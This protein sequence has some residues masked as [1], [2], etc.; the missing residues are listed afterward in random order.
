M[1]REDDRDRSWVEEFE[2]SDRV[3][4]LDR[5]W[6]QIAAPLNGLATPEAGRFELAMVP[7]NQI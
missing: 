2:R 7:L 4:S 1:G 3:D 5:V 6:D